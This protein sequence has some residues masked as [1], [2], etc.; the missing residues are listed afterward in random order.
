MNSVSIKIWR[1]AKDA[2]TITITIGGA[3]ASLQASTYYSPAY[4][5]FL[6]VFNNCVPTCPMQELHMHYGAVLQNETRFT[7]PLGS[8]CS[9]PPTCLQNSVVLS[10]IIVGSVFETNVSSFLT[11]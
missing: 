6:P 10:N 2:G 1:H 11:C 5:H 3:N 8:S 7:I 4:T 9:S